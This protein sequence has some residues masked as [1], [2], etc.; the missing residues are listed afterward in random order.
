MAPKVA[1]GRRTEGSFDLEDRSALYRKMFF[2]DMVVSWT[3]P[4]YKI[5]IPP[6]FQHRL[7]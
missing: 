2:A 3:S 6:S 7:Q 1:N 4:C 5:L